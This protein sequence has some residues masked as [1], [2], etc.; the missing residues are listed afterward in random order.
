MTLQRIMSSQAA[1]P[2]GAY[3]HAVRAGDLL[4]ASGQLSRDRQ[5][6]VVG[7]GDIEAQTAQVLDNL[8]LVLAEAGCSLADVAKVT[9]YITDARYRDRVGDVRRR[10]FGDTLPASTMVEVAGLG[11][12]ELMIEIEAVALVPNGTTGVGLQ[13]LESSRL[14][15]PIGAYVHGVRAGNLVFTSGQVARDQS[16]A[17]V[18]N[19]DVEA[20]TAQT[21]ES[22][23]AVLAE[24]GC[25]LADVLRTTTF[26]ADIRPR[27]QI[28]AVRRRYFGDHLGTSTMVGVPH[29]SPAILLEMEAT[30]LVPTGAGGDA[31][32]QR[33]AAPGAPAAAGPY[34]HAT[35][36]DRL[37]FTSGF[38]ARHRE[39]RLVGQ[40]DV[41]AQTAQAL[42][43][44]SLVLAEAS[45]T[46][47]DVAKMSTFTTD[48][49]Y[50]ERIG[51]VR[52]RYFGDTLPASTMV[53]VSQ[54]A[55]PEMLIEIDVVA[56]VP[57]R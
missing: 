21:M 5:G 19:G 2:G 51:G 12:P 31:G 37:V 25:T 29:L 48:L 50:R 13:R 42:E 24:A 52:R 41:E 36:A 4:F 16:G 54:L 46:L 56:M 27:D 10:Y 18:G 39:E 53:Q 8:G 40:G 14:P 9:S 20:Q 6:R 34:V 1:P 26:V 43:N 47:A 23:Q 7:A 15:P 38:T 55:S 45:C 49:R 11:D 28:S 30:A 44:L 22:I 32:L 3:V 57:E 33:L 17:V 35:R